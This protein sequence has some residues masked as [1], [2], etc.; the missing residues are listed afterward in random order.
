MGRSLKVS[1]TRSITKDIASWNGW[2]VRNDG[3][4]DP[5]LT[6]LW[7]THLTDFGMGFLEELTLA[8]ENH[9]GATELD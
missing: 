1:F 2:G 8:N 3:Q 5:S 6:G 4:R 9:Q 7:R